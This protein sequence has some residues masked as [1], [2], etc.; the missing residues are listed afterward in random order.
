[1]AERD[2]MNGLLRAKRPRPEGRVVRSTW[3]R[4]SAG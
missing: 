1:M 2:T 4:Q 3:Q